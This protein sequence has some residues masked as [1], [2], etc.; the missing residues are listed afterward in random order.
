LVEAVRIQRKSDS[1][2]I[3]TVRGRIMAVSDPI[4]AS[5]VAAALRDRAVQRFVEGKGV[6][7]R[8]YVANR[9]LN[10]VVG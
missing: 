8:V 10:L 4:G 2:R 9:L 5:V 7:K 3:M 1:L 6:R